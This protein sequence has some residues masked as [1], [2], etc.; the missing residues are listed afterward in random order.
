MPDAVAVVQGFSVAAA[1][2]LL[3]ELLP[4]QPVDAC[5]DTPGQAEM[6]E[7]GTAL[8]RWLQD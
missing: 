3:L 1:V 2:V 4:R 8:P 5:P 6:G 7:I